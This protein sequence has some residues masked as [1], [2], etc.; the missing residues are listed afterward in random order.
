MACQARATFDAD[1]ATAPCYFLGS[2]RRLSPN[3]P[4]LNRIQPQLQAML[5]PQQDAGQPGSEITVYV[6]MSLNREVFTSSQYAR[7]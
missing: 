2:G 3:A 5:T 6:R 7:A 4:C 1:A